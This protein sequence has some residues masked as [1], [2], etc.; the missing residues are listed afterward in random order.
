MSLVQLKVKYR[1]NYMH[2]KTIIRPIT[3]EISQDWIDGWF[4][5]VAEF[6]SHNGGFIISVRKE[7]IDEP[8]S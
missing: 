2:D 8:G 3:T 6:I 1:N 7:T 5:A 4:A